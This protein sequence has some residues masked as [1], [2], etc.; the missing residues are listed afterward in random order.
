M[1]KRNDLEDVRIPVAIFY[2]FDQGQSI[3]ILADEA[4]GLVEDDKLRWECCVDKGWA[5]VTSIG[6]GKCMIKKI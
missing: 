6:N 5:I 2:K 4:W 3:E 1:A